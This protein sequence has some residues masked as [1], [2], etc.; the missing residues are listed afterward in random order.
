MINKEKK[1][2]EKEIKKGTEK[3]KYKI[4]PLYS[5]GQINL[6]NKEKTFTNYIVLYIP[7]NYEQFQTINYEYELIF[8]INQFKCY[9]TYIHVNDNPKTI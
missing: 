1:K 2:K 6:I 3:E 7:K 9:E 5:K 4:K 8:N